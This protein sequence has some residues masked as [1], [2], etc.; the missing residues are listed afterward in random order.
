LHGILE[1]NELLVKLAKAGFDFLEV[2]GEALDLRGHGVQ[3][4]TGIGLNI[5]DGLLERA[6]GGAQLANRVVGLADERLHDG[7]VLGDL[8][9]KI[10]LT[11]KQGGDVALE[12][13]KFASDGFR[14]T[15][16]DKASGERAG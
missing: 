10:L 2:V 7:V 13:N 3:A 16:A 5:L 11:L 1:I 9:G 14:G 4:R 6:H 8:G 12:F 15:R